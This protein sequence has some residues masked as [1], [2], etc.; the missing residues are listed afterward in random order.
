MK[1]RMN[2]EL[3]LAFVSAKDVAIKYQDNVLRV[4][5]VIYGILKNKNLVKDII[6]KKIKDFE[7]L[8]REIEDFI[9]QTSVIDESINENTVLF[10]DTKLIIHIKK[11]TEVEDI[12]EITPEL[13]FTLAFDYE[14]P[15]FKIIKDYGL[16][17]NYFQK[18]LKEDVVTNI[19]SSEYEN[20]LTSGD[21]KSD[22]LKHE[23]NNNT[24]RSKTPTLDNYGRDLIK[25]AKENKLDPVIGRKN[26][27]ERISQILSR[28]RKNNP[29]IIGDAGVGKTALVESLAIKILNNDCPR[30]LQGKKIYALDLASLVAGT[31]YR[32]Q[33]EER[34]KSLLDEIIANPEI[35]IFIDE[36]HTLVGAGNS[37]GSLDAANVF[38]PALARGEIKCI[39]ATTQEEYHK[40]IEKDNALD[41]RF[42]KININPPTANETVEIL[43]NIKTYYENFHNV[44]YTTEAIKEIVRLSDR[45]ITDRQFPDKA[46]DVL[47]EAGSRAQMN[48]V[49]PQRIKDLEKQL[50]DIKLEKSLVVKNQNYEKAVDLRDLEKQVTKTLSKEIC[51]WNKSIKDSALLIDVDDIFS[52]MSS[53]SGIPINKLSNSEI[54]RIYTLHEEI[55]KNIIGQ[56]EAV[57]KVS[58][59]IKRN[60]VG[61]RKQTKPISTFLFIGPSGV[62]KTQL[63]KELSKCVF[64]SEESLIRIDMSEYSEKFNVSKLIGAPPGYVGYSEGGQLT[65]KIKKNPYCVILFDEIEKAHPEIFDVL[66]QLLDEGHLTDSDGKKINFKNTIII[67]TSNIG[68]REVQDFGVKIGFGHDNNKTDNSQSIIEKTLKKTFKPE[69][70]NRLDDVIYFN[71]L[72]EENILN[73]IDLQLKELSDRLSE[74]NYSLEVT[75]NAKQLICDLGYDRD[76]GAREI[77]RTIQKYLE[78]EIAELLLEHDMPKSAKFYVD[79]LDDNLK[80]TLS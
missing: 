46:I 74:S 14:K 50:E 32:G 49:V 40:H 52:V 29:L 17:K 44:T 55:Q 5:H 42:Q 73:I 61:I 10:F 19:T 36:I 2:D 24:V 65:Q 38:K 11:C 9:R 6:S 60:S 51:A 41:R 78:D 48:Y 37:S 58:S 43:M 63:A 68:L 31:K 33:F 26:E 59:A 3:K 4:E 8:L 30:P 34:L 16:T 57:K 79:I 70:L 13:F 27:V 71:Y 66:L 12:T 72:S 69:F 56:N 39:G 15:I 54:K 1:D 53:I 76:F 25:L 18:R 75:D 64:G 45:Y 21:D 23:N 62:G 20:R 77:Q 80:V 28:R 67:M 35:I 22:D 7:M 47:D